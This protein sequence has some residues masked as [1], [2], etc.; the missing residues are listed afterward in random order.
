M[1]A[2]ELINPRTKTGGSI[3]VLKETEHFYL[4]LGKLE[5]GVVEFLEA[6]KNYLRSNVTKQSLG[7]IKANPLHGRAITRDLDWGIPVPV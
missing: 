3:P 1:E 5:P 4:D 6:R 7:Q 2:N